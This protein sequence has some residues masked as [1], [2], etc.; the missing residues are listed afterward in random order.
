[1]LPVLALAVA[2]TISQAGNQPFAGTWIAEF[3][4]K[5]FVRIELSVANDAVRGRIGLGDIEVDAD[6]EVR[7]A[8]S[9]PADLTAIFDVAVRDST[10]SF[11]RKDG[12]DTDR[13]EMRIVGDQA[14]LRLL[15]SD[16]DRSELAAAGVPVPK[17]IRL[18]KVMR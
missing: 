3:E 15:L 6:G 9:A 14:E 11:S 18:K 8:A 13:F 7:M 5:T 17:P 12:A 2:V 1:M 4:G 10:L 16:E